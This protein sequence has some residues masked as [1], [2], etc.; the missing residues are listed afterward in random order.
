[1]LSLKSESVSHRLTRCVLL[2]AICLAGAGSAFGQISTSTSAS[3]APSP[4]DLGTTPV[5]T[6][7]V[8]ATDGSTP[9]SSVTCA[10][11]TRGH[12]ASYSANLQGGVASIPLQSVAQDPV[13]NYTLACTY[14]GSSNYAASSANTISFSIISPI[15][16]TTTVS[17]APSSVTYGS[18]PVARVTVTA[19]DGSTPTGSV[20]CSIQTRGHNAA[21]SSALTNGTAS[22]SLTTIAQDPVGTYSLV[23]SYPSY[24]SYTASS[25]ST[26]SLNVTQAVP[27]ITWASPAGVVYGTTLST[28]Q[29]NATTSVAGTFVYSPAAG[30]T[31]AVG[32][33]TLSVTF[34]PTDNSDYTSATQ[35]VS[36]AVN[37]AAPVITWATPAAATYGTALSATQLDATASVP[38]TFIYSPAAG[39]VPAVGTD[40]LSVTFTP[41]D[42]TDYNSVTA[43]VSQV[44]QPGPST[45]S[46]TLAPITSWLNYPVLVNVTVLNAGVIPTTSGT[47]ACVATPPSSAGSPITISGTLSPN[48]AFA[49]I[50][51]T[52]LPLTPAGSSYSVTCTFTSNNPAVVPS[53]SSITSPVYG[54][55]ISQPAPSENATAGQLQT[56]RAGHQ[57]TLLDDGTVIVT[58]GVAGKVGTDGNT[59]DNPGGIQILASTEIYTNGI[60]VYAAQ[61]TQPRYRHTATL[62]GNGQV[63]ITGGFTGSSYSATAELFT[64][65][66]TPGSLGTFAP[67]VQFDSSDGAF[68]GPTTT[69]SAPR[70]LHTATRLPNGNVLIT[71]GTSDGHSALS[72]A[73]LYDPTTGLFTLTSPMTT[74]RWMHTATLLNDGTVLIEGGA[75]AS[76]NTLASAEIYN[77]AN[78]QFT[79]VP[80]Q[81]LVGR[82][83]ATATLLGD[84][85]VL[86]TGGAGSGCGQGYPYIRQDPSGS[87]DPCYLSEAE[88]YSAGTFTATNSPMNR[89]RYLHT[90]ANLPDGTVLI[91]G[92]ITSYV[93]NTDGS[94]EIYYPTTRQFTVVGELEEPRWGHTATPIANLNLPG[95]ATNVASEVLLVGG[96]IGD[97]VGYVPDGT[98]GF[99]APSGYYVAT[100]EVYGSTWITGGLHPK[101]MV[102]D[103]MYAPP[104]SGSSINYSGQTSIQNTTSTMNAFTNAASVMLGFPNIGKGGGKV[105]N[106]GNS[107]QG[108]WTYATSGTATYSLTA[109]DTDSITAPGPSSS[110]LGVDHES[111]II[112]VW[113]NPESDYT[114]DT[115]QGLVWNG[116][117]TNPNDTNVSPDQMDIVPLTVSQLDGTS[118]IPQALLDILDRNWDPAAYG[119]AGGLT[120]TDFVTLLKRDPFATNASTTSFGQRA[121]LPTNTTAVPSIPVFDPNV[122]THDPNSTDPAQCGQRY[123]FDPTLGQT[124]PFSPLSI[125]NQADTSTFTLN[126]QTSLTKGSMETDTYSV[127]ISL[128]LGAA[129]QSCSGGGGPSDSKGISK[130]ITSLSVADT[131]T[132]V[133][134][135][136]PQ[137]VNQST[138]TQTLTIKNPLPK[139]NY[140]GP[141]EMQVWLDTLY[142]TYMF[143]PKPNDTIVSLQTSQSAAQS[144]SPVTLTATIVPDPNSSLYQTGSAPLPSQTVTF[145]DGCTV[146]GTQPTVAGVATLNYTWPQSTNGTHNLLAVYSGDSNYYHNVSNTLAQNITSATLPS[147]TAVSPASGPIGT[148]VTISGTNFGV[149]GAVTF[150]GIP[151]GNVTW[152]SA[153]TI[154]A[155]VPAGATTGSVIVTTGGYSSNSTPFTVMQAS[156]V[157]TTTTL[158]LSPATSWSGYSAVATALVTG[159]NSTLPA[160][161][162]SCV[163]SPSTGVTNAAATVN[164]ATGVAQVTILDAPVVPLGS[165]VSIPYTVTCTFTPTNPTLFASSQSN[166]ASGTVIPPPTATTGATGSLNIPRENHQATLLT[167]G[168]LLVT[169]GDAGKYAGANEDGPYVVYLQSSEI[170][171]NGSYTAAAEMT[172]PRSM[173]R[174]TLL[175]ASTGQVLITGGV[176]CENDPTCNTSTPLASAELFTP[177]VV[178]GSPGTFASTTLY[179]PAARGFTTTPTAMTTPRFWHTATQL[180]NGKVLIV[181]GTSTN[182]N[183]N[184]SQ[185]SFMATGGANGTTGSSLATAELYDPTTGKFTA[186]TGQMA[187]ARSRHTATLLTDGTVLIAGGI[188]ANGYSIAEAEIYDPKTD[189]FHVTKT[190]MVSG[191]I[192]AQATRLGNGTVLISGG[193]YGAELSG[194]SNGPCPLFRTSGQQGCARPD[195]EIYDPVAGTFTAAPNMNTARYSHTATLLYDGTVLISGGFTNGSANTVGSASTELYIPSGTGGTF[196]QIPDL[197]GSRYNH[198][199]TLLPGLGVLFVGGASGDTLGALP[200]DYQTDS[201]PNSELYSVPLLTTGLYPKFMVLNVIYAP[202]GVGSS[203]S[204][205]DQTQTGVTTSLTGSIQNQL[206]V[207]VSGTTGVAGIG[208]SFTGSANGSWT[209]AQTDAGSYAV[210]TTSTD[211]I[212][213]PGPCDLNVGTSTPLTNCPTT[214]TV[215]ATGSIKSPGVNHEADVILVWLNPEADFALP[216]SSSIVWD[217]FAT[218]QNDTNVATGQMDI[219]Q[220]TVGQLDGTT[221][222]PSDVQDVLDRNWDAVSTGGAGGLNQQ[223]FATILQRDPFANNLTGTQATPVAA[224]I[225]TDVPPGTT[226]SNASSGYTLVDPNI[227]VSVPNPNNPGAYE[228]S[229]RYQLS[230]AS[231]Q[232]FQFATLGNTNQAYSQNYSLQSNTQT[233]NQSS[234]NDQYDVGVS[235]GACFLVTGSDG[236]SGAKQSVSV[237]VGDTFTWGEKTGSQTSSQ[238]LVTQALTIKNPLPDEQY[239]GPVQMQ[240]WQDSLYGTF[241]FYPKATDTSIALSSSQPVTLA[242]YSV[243]LTASVIPDPTVFATSGKLPTGTITFYDGCEQIGT[244]QVLVNGIATVNTT[245][246]TASSGSH[247]ILAVYSGDTAYFNNDSSVFTQT[248]STGGTAIPYINAGGVQ[249]TSGSVGTAVQITGQ[250]FGTTGVVTFN[251]IPASTSALSANLITAT[252]PAGAMSGPL[253][254]T[255]NNYASNSVFFTV[256]VA[257]TQTTTTLSLTPAVSLTGKSV[258]AHVLV[259]GAISGTPILGSLSCTVTSLTGTVSVSSQITASSPSVDIALTPATGLP[260]LSSGG[261]S[262][263]SFTVSCSFTSSNSNYT[264]SQS[265]PATGIVTDASTAVS[266]PT[267]GL[268]V[269]RENQQ[270]NLLQDGTILVTGGDNADGPIATSEIFMG[271][272]FTLAAQLSVARTGHQA[273]LLSNSSGQVL[274][275]GGTDGVGDVYSSAELFT[276]GTVPGDPGAFGPTTLY[277]A[278]AGAFTS[279]VT[280]MNVA[281]TS[282]TATQLISGKVLITGGLDPNGN[283]L[284]SAELFDPTAGTF[285]YTAGSMQAA[286]HGHTATLLTDG[287]VLLTGGTGDI[288]AEIYTPATDSF[289]STIG[290]MT[291]SR[292]GAQATLLGGGTVLITGGQDSSGKIQNTAELYSPGTGTF[293]TT[294]DA[295]TGAPTP[296]NA[297][298]YAHTATLLPDGT[299]LIAGGQG[300]TGAE[301]ATEEIYDPGTGDFSLVASSMIAARSNQSATLTLGGN[302]LLA[303]GMNGTAETAA[304]VYSPSLTSGALFPKFMVLDVLYAPPGSGSTMTYTDGTLVGTSTSTDNT[305]ANQHAVA[306]S[307]TVPIPSTNVTLT[308]EVDWGH[309]VTQDGTSTFSLNTT[310]T[311]S[312]VVPG[313]VAAGTGGTKNIISTGVDHEADIIRVWLNPAAVYTLP[314]TANNTLIWNGFAANPNDPNVAPGAM[315]IIALTVSQLDGSA[316]SYRT[317]PCLSPELQAA[318]DRNWDSG[319][320]GSLGNTDFQTILQRDPFATNTSLNGAPAVP[321]PHFGGTSFDPNIPVPDPITQQ[322]S[323][324]YSFD[325]V[326]GQTFAFGQLGTTNQAQT[327][328]YS[329]QSTTSHVAGATTTDIYSV[330]NTVNVS[331][332]LTKVLNF[333]FSNK[334]TFTW[335]NKY[336]STR[337]NNSIVTQALA[338]KNP[339]LSDSYTGPTQM[340]VWRD[341]IYGTFMFYP[342]VTDTSVSLVSSQNAAGLGDSVVLAALVVADPKIAASS[343]PPLAPSGTITFYD[344][345]TVV[346]SAPVDT[347]TGTA[348]ITVSTLAL[349]SQNI[350]ASYSGDTNFLHNISQ[351]LTETVSSATAATPYISG[352]SVQSGLVGSTVT[353]NGVNFGTSGTVTFNGITASVTTGS[354]NSISV[355]VPVGAT[356]GPVVVT[357]SAGASNGVSFQVAQPSGL[358]ATSVTLNPA[359]SISGYP[360][361]VTVFVTGSAGSIPTGTVSCSVAAPGSSG[362]PTSAANSDAMLDATGTAQLIIPRDLPNPSDLPVVPRN[363]AAVNYSVTCNFNGSS[364]F[365]SSQSNAATGTIIAPP[366]GVDTAVGSPNVPREN[367]QTTLLSDGTILVTG[368]DNGSVPLSSAE[369]YFNSTFSLLANS[370][371]TARTGHQQTVLNSSTGQVLITGG[372]DGSLALASAELYTPGTSSGSPGTFKP[373]TLFNSES[374]T[375]TPTVTRMTS[376]RYL[377][378]ATLLTTSQVLIVGGRDQY[379]NALASAE[380]FNPA[381]GVFTPT[382]QNMKFARIGHQATLLLDG[383]VLITGG[384]DQYSNPVTAAEIYN[385]LTGVFTQTAGSMN[386]SRVNNQAT[387]LGSGM[388]LISGGQDGAG[389]AYNTAELYNPATGSFQVTQAAGNMQ[390]YMTG[391][392][393]NHTASLLA[394][395]TVLIAGGQDSSTDTL[396]T[397]ETYDPVAG[398]FSAVTAGLVVPHHNHTATVLPIA[399]VLIAGGTNTTVSGS[400]IESSAEVYTPYT[401]LA[402]LHPK[403]MVVNIQYAPPGSGSAMTYSNQTTMGTSTGSE[404]SFTHSESLTESVGFNLGVFKLKDSVQETWTNTQDSSSTFSLNNVTTDS[405]IVPGPCNVVPGTTTC[406]PSGGTDQSPGVEHEADVIWVWLNPVSDYII[407]SPSTF[408]WGGYASDPNDPNSPDGG[409]DVIPLSVSQLDGTSPVTQAEWDVLDRNWDPISSGGA[410]P[411]TQPDLQIILARDPFATN[412]SGVGRS[413]APT[414]VP[415]GSAYRIF[416]PNIPTY[417]PVTQQCG[418]RYDFTPGFDMTFP[419]SQLGSTNQAITQDYKLATTTAQS[420]STSTTDTYKVSIGSNLTFTQN[421]GTNFG[422]LGDLLCA[423]ADTPGEVNGWGAACHAID[424]SKAGKQNSLAATLQF[425]GYIQWTNKWTSSKNNSVLQTQDLSIKNPLATDNYTGS[426]QMQVWT[427]NLYGTFMFYPKPSDTSWVLSSSQ[428]TVSS[429]NMVTLNAMVTADPHVPAVPTG[430][431]TFYDGCTVLGAVNVNTAT[432]SVSLPVTLPAINGPQATGQ[433]TI[434][435]IYGGDMNFYHNNS[436]QVVITIQ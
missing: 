26:I 285:T 235:L 70:Y 119:G 239:T 200:V 25:S 377:H 348:S 267:T 102:L 215:P 65:G 243:A 279:T 363:G 185:V 230:G 383:T 378:T 316:C 320:A 189:T 270:A 392:R 184:A 281:R 4:V 170:Y 423:T 249:P 269:A 158:E 75:D 32:T 429:G 30:T 16:T 34:T 356:S 151:S 405:Q 430:T 375:F 251:G 286:R 421:I 419:F 321:P 238:T 154:Q 24:S 373:T 85:T 322:C 434:Q 345:C 169:G 101:F 335:T 196:T 236:C 136:N 178:P 148:T 131:L 214:S 263:A 258:N 176:N 353:V 62:L 190:P 331:L 433:H 177:G 333:S 195:T 139:D 81:M 337:T 250:N 122:P 432:G 349:G 384:V 130:V 166:T 203:V 314:P 272:S 317:I 19:S 153:G 94:E 386:V 179:D 329:L 315:D 29:L 354:T 260:T 49:Q 294:I 276:R 219:V 124:F 116:Y 17:V 133:N 403:F 123:A 401:I 120:A 157:S 300:A 22:I 64:P 110:G 27:V 77:P 141:N 1:M 261:A 111:D 194:G 9:D 374:Q 12:N 174:A 359:S 323:T 293:A 84:G 160:G 128:C 226:Y 241:M 140:T 233:Q 280:S 115:I 282:H 121:T 245:W 117:A 396:A 188:D 41:I 297:G 48:T 3:L 347:S 292:L 382:K 255:S 23:C 435:A 222:F 217:G 109:A 114:T 7:T 44:V 308:A 93:D 275:T 87:P 28:T 426:D 53:G 95:G 199:A 181:G 172:T 51:L 150:N 46:V 21:Y 357:T 257:P 418:N 273:T 394:D 88:T 428:S 168:T 399:G 192:R 38:G 248:V 224:T 298:R 138:S 118:P 358:T 355:V 228:C 149:S 367:Q 324:R 207:S 283:P 310:T 213:V 431:V 206:T 132:F 187:T 164:H 242:G 173:H 63:L 91:S 391:A 92:G 252:V 376:A 365:A 277:D 422:P 369:L 264:G 304:E 352:L 79:A 424:A 381:T 145:Y 397:M 389:N 163:S 287:T 327:Q 159:A 332:G 137:T 212:T 125:Q 186:T 334:N 417:D 380:L 232:T 11:Q 387:R 31:P 225:R 343:N 193:A 296:M 362:A 259:S 415:T 15:S 90:A 43:A 237:K 398:T 338:I 240:V 50:P 326:L 208:G 227:P 2:S 54:A 33:D 55:V 344:G 412:V 385:P 328:N 406:A 234:Y 253:V 351:A 8:T 127:G 155:V 388:V 416:D 167:D 13:G 366:N 37:K 60:F 379:G 370:M 341:N 216:T 80:N 42:T 10:I 113:L 171:S 99:T 411:I 246:A 180:L 134:Q 36:L 400:T 73:E 231:G 288:T 339:L 295:A 395:G 404:N 290:T 209:Y 265:N 312:V 182:G 340:Q 210:T 303:G 229:Q 74:P 66:Q 372:S 204:Y 40:T 364:G 211:A 436:N 5:A 244:P 368:G 301:L 135:W 129:T 319:G 413:T 342:H 6:V 161:Q 198:T 156:G 39:T 100:A 318:L 218:N 82:K 147:V 89:T 256:N 302:V 402:G 108:D 390:T 350:L 162:V 58:G 262:S 18:S 407:T 86:I 97:R 98:S 325:P 307:A 52:G 142:G 83:L 409:M 247:A 336:S 106:G 414:N 220:L 175:S 146:L 306:V 103:V 266:V 105:S 152:I 143:Y 268:H 47:I 309:T 393:F 221:P 274:V 76:G 165:S 67:T 68:D 278:A 59:G 291:A 223:D 289:K 305:F 69:M 35:A 20:S 205:T 360:V 299:V 361:T 427:D 183:Y 371:T 425:S 420:S 284:N 96:E 104:G 78:N 191:R 14:V 71:G 410:G 254:V 61:M 346:G 311:N 408:V 112:W 201:S 202:P 45:V 197:I 57:A 313:S 126:T 330:A 107:I 271:S 56:P 144:G 72:S